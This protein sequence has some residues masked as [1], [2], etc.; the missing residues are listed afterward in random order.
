MNPEDL[1]EDLMSENDR[2]AL[3]SLAEKINEVFGGDEG[4]V[5]ALTATYLA[6]KEA[7]QRES[8]RESA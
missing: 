6:G 7:G 5:L 1:M 2:T 8:D 3:T 4:I